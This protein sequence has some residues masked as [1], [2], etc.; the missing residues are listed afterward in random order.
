MGDRILEATVRN[1]RKLASRDEYGQSLNVG[2]IKWQSYVLP[3]KP[4]PT[5]VVQGFS[6]S[7]NACH[8][9]IG[10]CEWRAEYVR[11]KLTC[12]GETRR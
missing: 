12:T 10:K 5:V 6:R 3:T 7:V 8:F 4:G 11:F 9:Q 1:L 2:L